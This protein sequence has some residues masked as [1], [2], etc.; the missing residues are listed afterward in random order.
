MAP[1]AKPPPFAGD[2]P[3][4]P[5]YSRAEQFRRNQEKD[6]GNKVRIGTFAA[7][8]VIAMSGA[9]AAQA[10]SGKVAV[11]TSFSKD[12]TDPVQEGL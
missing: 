11:V 6:G 10:P 7:T 2:V 8:L 3:N 1:L 4:G 5:A 9:A 12:V